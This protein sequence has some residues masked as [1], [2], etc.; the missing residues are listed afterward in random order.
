MKQ[1]K[2]INPKFRFGV[3]ILERSSTDLRV[4]GLC[5]GRRCAAGCMSLV[6]GVAAAPTRAANYPACRCLSIFA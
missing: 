5:Q 2:R 1:G 3:V 6:N 4:C